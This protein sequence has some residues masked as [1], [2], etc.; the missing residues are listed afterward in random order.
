MKESDIVQKM[1]ENQI[2]QGQNKVEQESNQANADRLVQ[3][4]AE[5]KEK[6]A[7]SRKPKLRHGDYGCVCDQNWAHIHGQTFWTDE[8]LTVNN[9]I[10]T[11]TDSHFIDNSKEILNF[12][13]D[14]KASMED[15]EKFTVD[16]TGAKPTRGTVTVGQ[17]IEPDDIVYMRIKCSKS[18]ENACTHFTL[19]EYEEFT[20]SH[21]KKLATLKRK[22]AKQ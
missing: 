2:K 13:G 17:S 22:Q 10:S 19:E 16:T 18:G 7:E 5:L 12:A 3:E 14:L 21:R 4:L 1:A 8:K 15:V 20:M 11:L 9:R 6:L